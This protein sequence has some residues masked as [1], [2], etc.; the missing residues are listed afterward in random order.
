MSLMCLHCVHN[1]FKTSHMCALQLTQPCRLRSV[2]AMARVGQAQRLR[3][4]PA[5]DVPFL[6]VALEKFM[7]GRKSRDLLGLLQA[8]FTSIHTLH[9]VVAMIVLTSL[10]FVCSLC[11]TMLWPC[12][13][14]HHHIIYAKPCCGHACAHIIVLRMFVVQA[15]SW[16]CLRLHHHIIVWLAY[17]LH[18]VVAMLVLT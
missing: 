1:Y 10:H 6:M 13:C 11:K 15:M 14:S 9:H 17:T 16:P 2:V 12:L 5:A 18:H 7:E 4:S 3:F 8:P